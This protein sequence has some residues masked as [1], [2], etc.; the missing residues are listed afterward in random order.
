VAAKGR[1]LI[2]PHESVVLDSTAHALKFSGF[3]EMYFEDSFPPEYEVTPKPELI[4]APEL[5]RPAD[6]EAVPEPGQPLSG[7]K[8][9]TFVARMAKEIAQ[10]LDLNK[11]S[12]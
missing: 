3:Q 5:I 4:N 2:A 11:V 6:L 7:E 1:G 9:D 10:I 12:D 8:L